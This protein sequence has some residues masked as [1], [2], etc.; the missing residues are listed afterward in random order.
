MPIDPMTKLQNDLER[1]VRAERYEE[2]ARLRDRIKER[3]TESSSKS[4]PTQV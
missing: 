4:P 1:A 2:A 3:E